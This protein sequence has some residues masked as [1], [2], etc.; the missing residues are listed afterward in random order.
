MMVEAMAPATVRNYKSARATRVRDE[1]T[2]DQKDNVLLVGASISPVRVRLRDDQS[3]HDCIYP[4]AVEV[5]T[6][7]G[8]NGRWSSPDEEWHDEHAL[9]CAHRMGG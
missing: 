9:V 6:T 7:E 1:T 2:Y 5:S 3:H 8:L 4:A